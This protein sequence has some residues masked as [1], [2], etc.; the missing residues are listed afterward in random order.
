MPPGVPHCVLG[1]SNAI[2]VGRHFFAASTIRSSV[3]TIVHTFLLGL[4]V[5]NED[6]VESRT[7]LYQL[8]VFWLMRLDIT[9][10]DGTYN[11]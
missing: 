4:S 8:I 3:I 9:D 6:F 7:F 2:C 1:T 10:V 11:P 5:T